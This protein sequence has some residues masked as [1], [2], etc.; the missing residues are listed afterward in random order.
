MDWTRGELGESFDDKQMIAKGQV[1]VIN[2]VPESHPADSKHTIFLNLKAL[3]GRESDFDLLNSLYDRLHDRALTIKEELS[4]SHQTIFCVGNFSSEVN[5]NRY[6]LEEKNFKPLNTLY[7]MKRDLHQPVQDVAL[8]H[9]NLIWDFWKMETV[10]EEK[11]YLAVECEIWPDAALGERRLHEYKGNEDWTAISVRQNGNIIA[12]TMAWKDE[13][14][15]VIEDVFVR[16]AWRKQGIARFLLTKA[17][18]YL[19]E[20][21]LGE[22][23]LMVDTENEKA[24]NL[25]KSVGFEVVE[26]EKRYFV[27][28][29]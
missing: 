20:K 3:P 12:C 15:G 22:A 13:E 18:L 24:L 8:A 4:S 6:F 14:I 21:G 11:E 16:E 7:T 2:S 17:L 28:L 27:E 10:E 5:N 26:E 25:Y 19:K 29:V 9:G 23:Q 1:E